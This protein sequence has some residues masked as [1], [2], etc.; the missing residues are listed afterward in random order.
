[1][2]SKMIL[3]IIIFAF[4]I[5]AL[6]FIGI[7]LYVWITYASKSVNEIPLWALFFMFGGKRGGRN[8]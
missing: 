1:M 6:G 5:L 8:G 3:W 7:E 2:K 4:A